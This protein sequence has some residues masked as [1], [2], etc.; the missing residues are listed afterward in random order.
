MA[1]PGPPAAGRAFNPPGGSSQIVFGDYGASMKPAAPPQLAAPAPEAPRNTVS[2]ALYYSAPPPV[3]EA[4]TAPLPSIVSGARPLY[5]N[6][7]VAPFGTD[8]VEKE[9]GHA[10]GGKAGV[11]VRPSQVCFT[12]TS[13][14]HFHG[15]S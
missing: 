8:H 15:L 1:M 14:P 6:P 9:P 13:M 4:P 12:L 7:S 10:K 11:S 3:V 2:A 5:P